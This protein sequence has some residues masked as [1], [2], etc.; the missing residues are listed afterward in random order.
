MTGERWGRVAAAWAVVAAVAGTIA[1]ACAG[2]GPGPGSWDPQQSSAIL[3]PAND[4][5]Q[6]LLLLLADRYGTP[7]ADPRAMAEGIVPI[8]MP[9]SVMDAR[10]SPPMTDEERAA[11]SW[12]STDFTRCHSNG[13]GT[14]QFAA[15]VQ[16]AADIEPSEKQA[17]IASREA[18]RPTCGG[19]DASSHQLPAVA[20]AAARQFADYLAGAIATRVLGSVC[21][22]RL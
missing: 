14:A 7:T 1:Y 6:N 17:L 20:S 8:E 10:L 2:G 13:S 5:R 11:A 19:Q 16:A 12:D 21:R 22:I 4:T 9:W 18:L 3:S 15:A